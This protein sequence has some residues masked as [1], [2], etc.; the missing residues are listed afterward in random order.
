MVRTLLTVKIAL[1]QQVLCLAVGPYLNVFARRAY[2][3]RGLSIARSV[4]LI[5]IRCL[6]AA[7]F[8]IV[9]ANEITQGMASAVVLNA[10]FI[11]AS[12]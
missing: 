11:T 2:M 8:R 3:G 4:Q 1:I 5:Q 6:T 12:G 9:L 7:R 10:I